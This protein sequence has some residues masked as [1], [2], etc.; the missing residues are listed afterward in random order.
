MYDNCFELFMKLNVLGQVITS[1]RVTD[2][3]AGDAITVYTTDAIT[4]DLVNITQTNGR[5]IDVNITLAKRLDCDPVCTFIC[6]PAS[7][8]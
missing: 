4:D 8:F 2:Q 7:R 5:D 1:F 3:D 6:T